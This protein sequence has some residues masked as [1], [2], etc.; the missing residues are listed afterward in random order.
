M[1]SSPTQSDASAS[2]ANE[3]T[4][5]SSAIPTPTPSSSANPTTAESVDLEVPSQTTRA[6]KP[7]EAHKLGGVKRKLKSKVWDEFER[8]LVGGKWK[9]ECVWCHGLFCGD[10]KYG[11]SH[12]H[13]HLA[14]CASMQANGNLPSSTIILFFHLK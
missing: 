8:V 3:D 12:L 2:A 4:P 11:S 1:A 13:A 6:T 14:R 10:P 5:A 9:A 7:Q